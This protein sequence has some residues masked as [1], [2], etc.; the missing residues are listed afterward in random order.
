MGWWPV[1]MSYRI[2][3]GWIYAD[4]PQPIFVKDPE[5]SLETDRFFADPDL[6][7]S[8]ARLGARGE[9]S[10]KSILAWVLEHG[11]LERKNEKDDALLSDT[12]GNSID[13]VNQA[14]I[15]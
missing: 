7:L 9:P 4:N 15:T 3:D 6:F 2:L 11:L 13:E 8:F 1:A 12:G 5:R 10:E 14:P